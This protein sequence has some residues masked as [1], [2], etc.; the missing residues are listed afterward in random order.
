MHLTFKQSWRGYVAGRTYD[1]PD[2]AAAIY[3]RRRI[4]EPSKSPPEV[5]LQEEDAAKTVRKP[6]A[7]PTQT[8]QPKQTAKPKQR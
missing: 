5:L 3:L 4:A 2:G 8:A 1:V 7:K 6:S